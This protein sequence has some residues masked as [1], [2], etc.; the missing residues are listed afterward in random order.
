MAHLVD[1]VMWIVGFSACSYPP[2]PRLDGS[3]PV[4]DAASADGMP[5]DGG[6][7]GMPE[8]GGADGCSMVIYCHAPGTRC[9]QRGCSLVD[10]QNECKRETRTV[11]GTPVCPFIFATSD[12]EITLNCDGASCGTNTVACNGTCCASGVTACDSNG[13][14]L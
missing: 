10:A 4:V 13:A 3:I 14:C 9:M 2:L 5:E 8:D 11:C 1:V 6:A 7:D 12:Q